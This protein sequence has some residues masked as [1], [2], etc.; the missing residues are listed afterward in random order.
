[1]EQVEKTEYLGT[2][3]SVNRKIDAEINNRVQKANQIYY[4][5]I[6]TLDGKKEINSNNKIKIYKMI[7]L[8]TIP[9][10]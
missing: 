8:P 3:I 9:Y 6:Q 4:Q 10:G 5:I 7:Y 1:M 2:I